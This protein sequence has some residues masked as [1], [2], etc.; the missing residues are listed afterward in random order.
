M[1]CWKGN[2]RMASLPGLNFD[3]GENADMLRASVEAFAVEEIAPRAATID[4]DN[5]FP[6]DLWP[7]MGALGVLGVTAAEDY[8]GAGLGYLEPVVA[9]AEISPPPPPGGPG[10]G[11]H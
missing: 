10:V 3:L 2:I 1:R 6:M 9:V 7:K 4:R 8:G 11:G 5:A